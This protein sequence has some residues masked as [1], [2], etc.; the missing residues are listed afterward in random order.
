MDTRSRDEL[1]P[2]EEAAARLGMEPKRLRGLI[3]RNGIG[4]PIGDF[5]RV[6]EWSLPRA[7]DT[8]SEVQP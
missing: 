1:I 4:D 6:Y 7:A 2:V 3:M 8:S 5:E